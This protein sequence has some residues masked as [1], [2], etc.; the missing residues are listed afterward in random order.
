MAP[1]KTPGQ[2]CCDADYTPYGQEMQHTE[3]LQ[4]AACPPSYRFT[5]YEFDS[6]TGLYY[7]FARYYSP[8]L[9]RFCHLL[10]RRFEL[11][12]LAIYTVIRTYACGII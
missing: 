8:L 12:T 1:D 2:L 11:L 3:R 6:E 9:G 4:A 7:A 5:G 10:T